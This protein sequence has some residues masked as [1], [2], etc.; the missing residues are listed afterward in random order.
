MIFRVYF[1]VVKK[2]ELIYNRIDKKYKS[3]E[4]FGKKLK[5]NKNMSIISFLI[6]IAV[7]IIILKLIALPF[8]IIIK[9]II[10]SIIGGIVLAILSALGIGI[11]ITWVTVVLTGLLG[12][13]GLIISIILSIIF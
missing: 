4:C 8:K 12:I 11:A 5:T 1:F 2:V 13:P 6:A 9:F 7:L 10:N 3:K